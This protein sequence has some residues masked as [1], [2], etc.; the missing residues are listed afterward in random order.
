MRTVCAFANDFE[1]L[2]CGYVVRGQ[3]CDVA[4]QSIFS[5][6]GISENQ[7]DKIQREL[8][9][10][11]LKIDLKDM[12]FYFSIFD[13]LSLLQLVVPSMVVLHYQFV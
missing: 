3:D 9:G 5:P 12:L 6:A 8:L 11:Q 1:N 13:L 2:S 4:G 7:L 10:I